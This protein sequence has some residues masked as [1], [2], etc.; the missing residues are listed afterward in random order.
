LSQAPFSGMAT[1][2]PDSIEAENYDIGGEGVSFHD[3]AK[4]EGVATQRP[5]DKVDIGVGG[6]NGYAVAW[7]SAGEWLEYTVDVEAGN[8][9]IDL[10]AS[11]GTTGGALTMSLDSKTIAS[12][13]VTGT[14]DWNLYKSFKVSNIILNAA[15]NAILRITSTG[16]FNLDKLTFVKDFELSIQPIPNEDL[17][18]EIYPNPV[19]KTLNVQ[20]KSNL[21]P[22]LKIYN[23]QSKL[24]LS[25]T[26]NNIDV[27]KLGSGMYILKVNDKQVVKFI[28][29]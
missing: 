23:L 27:S 18:S 12:I 19:T 3:D 25:E 8:Y 10:N 5:D 17:I 13:N 26:T 2:I 21:V 24:L 20:I 1:K 9:T 11:S 6:S 28:K 14:A 4:K 7:F 29:N 22:E 15:T 16:G